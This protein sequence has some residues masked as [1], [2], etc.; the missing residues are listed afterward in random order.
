[1]ILH[2]ACENPT[3]FYR[4]IKEACPVCRKNIHLCRKAIV[5]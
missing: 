2:K 5:P 4:E 1:V 3:H